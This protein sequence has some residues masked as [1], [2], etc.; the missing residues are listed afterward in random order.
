MQPFPAIDADGH[1]R[2][3]SRVARISSGSNGRRDNPCRLYGLSKEKLPPMVR[4]SKNRRLERR[5]SFQ[6]FFDR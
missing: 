2:A 3:R 4:P 1:D 6:C 5:E